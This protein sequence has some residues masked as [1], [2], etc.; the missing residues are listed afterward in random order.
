MSRGSGN[1][2]TGRNKGGHTLLRDG[3]RMVETAPDVLDEA[4]AD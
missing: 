1:V 4:A 2:L 3:A